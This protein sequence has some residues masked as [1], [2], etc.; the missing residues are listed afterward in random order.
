[1]APHAI[2]TNKY[3]KID[4]SVKYNPCVVN[5]GIVYPGFKSMAHVIKIA[6]TKNKAPKTGYI[7]PI[8]LSIGNI[9]AMKK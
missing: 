1:M 8:I 6:M 4:L 3:G 2:V 5:S 9:V 7:F